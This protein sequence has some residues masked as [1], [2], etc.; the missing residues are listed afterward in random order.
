MVFNP[1]GRSL[2]INGSSRRTAERRT[3]KRRN[4][5]AAVARRR[6]N[7]IARRRSNP[8]SVTGLLV[9]AVMAGIGVSL[10]DA[11]TSRIMPQNS[12]LFSVGVKLGGAWLFQSPL[13]AKVP[14]LGKYKNDIALVL[15]TI[16]IVQAMNMYVLPAVAGAVNSLGAGTLIAAPDDTTSGIYGQ[17]GVPIW[18]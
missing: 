14:V 5:V 1:A 12:G 15:A 3:A 13:G 8:A 11:V 16:G 17:Q 7:P 4:P 9:T 2:T 18:G 6:S 10:F